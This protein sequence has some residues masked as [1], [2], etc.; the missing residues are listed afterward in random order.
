MEMFNRVTEI[1]HRVRKVR[2]HKADRIIIPA[3]MET[4]M[5]ISITT[6]S[7]VTIRKSRRSRPR[8][9]RRHATIGTMAIGIDVIA[10][11]S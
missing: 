6:K 5:L 3:K 1:Q 8:R 11:L 9:P 2:S 4:K 10:P 7:P